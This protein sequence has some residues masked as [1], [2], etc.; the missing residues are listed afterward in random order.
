MKGKKGLK[1]YQLFSEGKIQLPVLEQIWNE[2]SPAEESGLL[3]DRKG[4]V[5]EE[6]KNENSTGT[7]WK[8]ESPF[9]RKGIVILSREASSLAEVEERFIGEFQPAWVLLVTAREQGFVFYG[10]QQVE[11]KGLLERI[12]WG[13]GDRDDVDS[14]DLFEEMERSWRVLRESWMGKTRERVMT[15]GIT[16]GEKESDLQEMA[17]LVETAG[18]QVIEEIEQKR[19]RPDPAY[20]IGRGKVTELSREAQRQGISLVIFDVELTPAQQ[21]NLQE[22]VQTRV[23]DRSQLILDI[24]ARHAHTREGQIQVELAQLNYL[25]PRLVGRGQELS[26]L[27]GGIGTRGPGETKLEVDRRRIRDRI[28]ELK[29]ELEQIKKQRHLLQKGRRLPFVAMVGYTNAGKSTLLN[30]LTGSEVKTAD[31]LFAT[32]DPTIRGCRLPDGREVLFTDTVGFIKN[33]PHHLIAA[34]RATL[35]GVEQADALLMVVDSCHPRFSEQI[36][37]V[38]EVLE[39]LEVLDKPML[40]VFNKMDLFPDPEELENLVKRY[41]PSVAVSARTGEN[42]RALLQCL[43]EVLGKGMETRELLIPYSQAGIIDVLHRQAQVLQEEYEDEG[44][45]LRVNIG[46]ELYREIKGQ[47]DFS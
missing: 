10:I 23:I 41:E 31:Q 40:T 47:L 2:V 9:S 17:L 38:L 13:P 14:R 5:R 12:T 35:E 44:I 18:G 26:R 1:G 16:S 46:E 27:A 19:D 11:K 15:V 7:E 24:F 4:R 30:R 43:G 42:V 33:I 37:T 25:L 28:A 20:Y 8:T 6:I 29:K 39:E 34:F 36:E 22:S 3:V 32:L 21:H 45:R